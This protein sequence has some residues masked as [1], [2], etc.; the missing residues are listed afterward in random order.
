M[1]TMKRWAW[2]LM[3]PALS[4]CFL[5]PSGEDSRVEDVPDPLRGGKLVVPPVADHH[6]Y[7]D[8]TKLQVGQWATY[9]EGERTLTLAAVG[10]EGEDVWI[11]VV[12]EGDP[13]RVSARL[14]GPDAGVKKALYGEISKEGGLAV[15]PQPLEQ[16]IAPAAPNAIESG[17]ETG[18]EAVTIGDR[19]L[20][21]RSLRVRREDLEGRVTE[22]RTLWHS[23]VPPLYAGSPDGGLIRKVTPAFSV[24]LTAFGSGAKPLLPR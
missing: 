2:V 13:R 7:G 15:E 16:W 3:L 17:R 20:T 24:E 6:P 8:V 5:F 23:D 1:K 19:T 9:R 11:E 14:V 4:G 21:A 12:E 22:E 18:E 10:R